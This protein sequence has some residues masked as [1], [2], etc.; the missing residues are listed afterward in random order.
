MEETKMKTWLITGCSSGIGEGI[1]KA[2]LDRGDQAI[3]T[4]RS[5]EKVKG[6]QEKYPDTCLAVRLD[7]LDEASVD[8][9]LRLGREKF[10]VID[11]LVNN[12]GHGYRS[13]VEEGDV[14]EVN[15]LFQTNFFGPIELIKKV[16]PDMRAQRS[17][18]IINV[19]SI[20][21]VRSAVGSGYYAAS[22]AALELA[23]EGLAQ[24]VEPLGIK[25]LIVEPGA[26][27]TSFYRES[28]LKMATHKVGDYAETAW[29]RDVKYVKDKVDQLGDP[30]KAGYAIADLIEEE[31]PPR[32]YLMGSDAADKIETVLENRL[33][34]LR[35]WRHYS[36]RTDF[37]N[38]EG[39]AV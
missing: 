36:V 19:T 11:V 31:N 32:R 16:L 24:E 33:K 3:V 14:E 28:N 23:S 34:E 15:E 5:A 17:G 10:G 26:F 39:S 9:A 13:S 18:A 8:E 29:T 2:V 6:L 20:A 22:K 1:A 27:R 25:V 21:G 38:G 4:A 7:V 37:E 12:A 30:S 35:A